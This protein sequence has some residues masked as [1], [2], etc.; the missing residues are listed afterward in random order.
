MPASPD[1][2]Q[3]YPTMY[4]QQS[5]A[6][7]SMTGYPGAGQYGSPMHL[8]QGGNYAG[9]VY[10]PIQPLLPGQG[11]GMPPSFTPPPQKQRSNVVLVISCIFL[12]LAI[13]TF[14]AFGAFYMLR[15]NS[16]GH[17][18]ANRNA[19]PTSVATPTSVLSPS[20]TPSPTSSPSPTLTTTPAPDAGFAWCDTTC[21]SNGFSVEYPGTWLQKPTSDSTGTQFANPSQL[22]EFAAFKT[23]GITTMNAG[24]LVNSDLNNFSSQP[25][26]IT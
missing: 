26:Y 20:P 13:I 25:S 5:I 15:N 12:A 1:N 22:D 17:P 10:P 3:N 11:Y 14:G 8:S 23:P 19:S 16:S 7:P 21:T 2:G 24:Q 4:P 6:G 18:T 9:A